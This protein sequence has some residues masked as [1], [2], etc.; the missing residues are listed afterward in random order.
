MSQCRYGRG[1]ASPGS[2][3]S[4]DGPCA[5]ASPGGAAMAGGEPKVQVPM[6]GCAPAKILRTAIASGSETVRDLRDKGTDLGNKYGCD[7]AKEGAKFVGQYEF[8]E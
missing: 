3:E 1:E 2:N 6:W 8:R 5:A 7:R 4:R